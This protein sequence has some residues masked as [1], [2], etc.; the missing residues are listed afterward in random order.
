[1]QENA[2]DNYLYFEPFVRAFLLGISSSAILESVHTLAST[3][4]W[5]CTSSSFTPLFYADHATALI[6]WAAFYMLDVIAI[7][8]VLKKYAED[9]DAAGV[10]LQKLVT[11]PQRMLPLRLTVFKHLLHL[12][13]NSSKTVQ[14]TFS[15]FKPTDAP[16][17][18]P[19]PNS[20]TL[21]KPK[22]APGSH[23]IIPGTLSGPRLGDHRAKKGLKP[24]ELDPSFAE[25]FSK[26]RQ[27]LL[28]RRAYLHGF[29]YAAAISEA[30]KAD[31]KPVGVNVLDQKIVLF[32]DSTTGAVHALDDVC[33]H[34]GAPFSDGWVEHREGHTCVVCPYHGWAVGGE[35]KI[36]HVP[37]AE[38]RGEWPKR[39]V[40]PIY[41][42]EERG[43]FIWLWY[44]SRD[45]P[46]DARPPIPCVPELENPDWKAVYGEIEFDC[47]HT[48]VFENALDF[49]HIHFLHNDS[50]GN[51]EKPEIRNM[52]I[53]ASDALSVTATFHLCNKPAS[54]FWEW[55]KVPEVVV[56]AKAFLPSTSMISFT[57]GNGLSFITFVN[58]V[59][60]SENKSVNRFALVRNLAWDKTGTF[61]ASAWDGWARKAMFKILGEDKIMVEK[62]RPDLLAK[63]YSVRADLPQIEFRKLRQ[64]WVDLGYVRP[65]L[66]Q[67]PRFSSPFS[68]YDGGNGGGTTDNGSIHG[69]IDGY[70]SGCDA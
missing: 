4:F 29:W 25:T 10:A 67:E 41:D 42:V 2:Q 30:V 21:P 23:N 50:F 54:V 18:T 63:E 13:N 68:R 16:T 37:A 27:E 31:G 19:F 53:T 15:A 14:D 44:G 38:H 20:P 69:S 58:T 11:L 48:S 40:V 65:C 33:P 45:L 70:T 66:G 60:I 61:N 52:E 9:S 3:A 22:T 43:G 34:R 35:G 39:Q 47:S 32:R 55:S 26:R 49:A 8:H 56:T 51:Q 12:D 46:R 62:L 5:G 24:G 28:D 6:G 59:P 36:H 1:M 7:S 17:E 64:Q 57:L